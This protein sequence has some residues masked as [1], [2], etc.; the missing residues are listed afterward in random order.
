M[1][2]RIKLLIFG[3]LVAATT[4]ASYAQIKT[5]DPATEWTRSKP[6]V[7]VYKPK[8]GDLNDG[9]N[10]HFLV[11]DSPKGDLLA[12]WTQSSVEGRGDNHI[13][14]ARSKDGLKWSEPIKVIG[15]SQGE[16]AP[17]ASW[18][19]PVVSRKGRIYCFY[20]KD[21]PTR[22]KNGR[23][24][25][26]NDIGV[27]YSDDDGH[28]WKPGA[29]VP[30]PKG[31]YDHPNGLSSVWNWI[32]W[33]KP[34]RDRKGRWLVGYS[35]LVSPELR[36]DNPPGWWVNDSGVKFLRFENLDDSP[37]P[38]ELRIKHLMFEGKGLTVKSGLNP[39][40]TDAEEPSLSLLPDNR[41]FVT[42]RTSTG[43]IWYS[44]SSDDGETWRTPEVLRY[45][46]NGEPIPHPKAPCPVYPMN[47]GR[48]VLL[49]FNNPG[50]LGPYDQRAPLEEF[51]KVNQW[52]HIRRPAHI[53]LG[54]FRPGAHQPIW[55]SQPRVLM[56]TD[57]IIVG[58][59]KTAEIA[60]YTSF[61]ETKG[62][63]VLW[64][65]DR[66]YYLLGKFITDEWLQGM[67]VDR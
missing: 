58:P 2:M 44:V 62:R 34:I 13:M 5:G 4:I 18:G 8:Q 19:F 40:L 22:D 59:K 50:K 21:A 7:V 52:S 35:Y 1:H 51:K 67:K 26:T 28:T 63:R 10:E 53:A 49:Y 14:L 24:L 32:V 6:D 56:D 30:W 64:Y 29:D 15:P 25:K 23:T 66:K 43:Y 38:K 11:F 61:T 9:D 55:F 36:K 33:Q 27:A 57:G 45:K 16:T 20:S 12:M 48:Y 60:T 3:V 65:P 47:D 39:A 46:D 41:L 54:E 31:Q 37:D 17:Q 42:M